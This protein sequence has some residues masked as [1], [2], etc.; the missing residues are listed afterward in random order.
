MFYLSRGELVAL[1]VLLA[2][3]LTGASM[4][5]YVKVHHGQGSAQ[6]PV[7]V[8]AP[9]D[10]RGRQIV[11]RVSGAVVTPGIY[12][13]P[14]GAQP[15]DAIRAAG[16]ATDRAAVESLS[17]PA[18]VRDGENILVPYQ[19]PRTATETLPCSAAR[20]RNVISLNRASKLD[21]ESLPGI[22]PVY[23]ERIIAYREKKMRGEGRGF[24]STDELLNIPGIGPKRFAAIRHLVVP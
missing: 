16:G 9:A 6:E 4:V 13:L 1:S 21:L 20:G 3:L 5:G 18:P 2:L 10:A 14:E 24:Q 23:A 12:G 19:V 15:A 11:V 17:L 8:P 7:L 22:G